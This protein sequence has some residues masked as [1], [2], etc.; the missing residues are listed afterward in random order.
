VDPLAELLDR[1]SDFLLRQTDS[2]AF[3]IQV[4]AFLRALQ[5]EPQLVAYLDN[6]L[7]EVADIVGVM[8]E[9]DGELASELTELRH[10]L[11]E[12]RPRLMTQT[13][14]PRLTPTQ[15]GRARSQATKRRSRSS[16]NT[17]S[18]SRVLSTPTAKVWAKTL[19]SILQKKDAAYV[20][21]AKAAASDGVDAAAEPVSAEAPSTKDQSATNDAQHE[22]A[23]DPMDQWRRRLG[24]VQRRYDHAVRSMTLHSRTSA[25]LALI[26]LEAV[27]DSLTPPAR[28]LEL[29]DESLTATSELLRS[30]AARRAARRAP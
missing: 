7:E 1:Q 26:K 28:V 5:T 24:N 12:H 13:P 2:E 10:E 19:L 29:D 8:E 25:G 22:P 16:T 4:E 9:A 20:R 6:V 3:L 30:R 27:P 17:P 23:R 18:P 14:R 11:V 21:E 15:A